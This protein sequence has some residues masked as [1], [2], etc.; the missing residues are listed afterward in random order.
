MN[1][2][3]QRIAPDKIHLTGIRI[4]KSHFEV[5]TSTM[6]ES[7]A[8]HSFQTGLKSESGH[9][10]DDNYQLFSLFVKIQGLDADEKLIG[11]NAEYHIDFHYFIDNLG[12]FITK[13]DKSEEFLLGSD[14][15]ATLAG[16]SYSTCRGII[17]DRTQTTDFN[18][19][20]LPVINPL[21]LI[22]EDT[23]TEMSNDKGLKST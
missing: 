16:I 5:D 12:D 10:L 20:I 1:K 15:G 9:N 6:D 13:D 18:G 8:I 4:L 3:K 21:K 19:L 22:E 14:L 2:K 11:V 23:F 17:L 7:S